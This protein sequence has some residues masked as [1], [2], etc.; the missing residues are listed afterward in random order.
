MTS[1]AEETRAR[2]IEAATREF[3]AHGIHAASLLEITRQAGQRNRGA[4]HYH[5]G[6]REGMLAAVL[7]QQVD[8]L[9]EREVE[10]LARARSG[11]PDDLAPVIEAFVCP[12]LEL[13][14]QGWQGRC[15]LV[16]LAEIVED[17]PTSLAP[18]VVEV[19]ERTG[20]QAA[21]SLLEERVPAM[22]EH[23]LAERLSLMISFLL[24]AVADRARTDERAVPGRAHLGTE[25][26]VAN[27][28]AMVGGM[29][30]APVPPA[31]STAPTP[32]RGEP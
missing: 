4:V 14:D 8:F 32:S 2:L 31:A 16:I 27:L 7:E 29:L 5:F 9:A 26:F 23:V 21:V 10:L 20:G 6:S 3:A 18:E 25:A 12:A 1:Q 22:P 13:A 19:L 24:R 17:D 15:Y 30:T 28:V 11:P